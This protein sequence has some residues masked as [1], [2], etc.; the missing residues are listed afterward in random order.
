VLASPAIAP[1][2]SWAVTKLAASAWTALM[3]KPPLL[4]ILVAKARVTEDAL[5]MQAVVLVGTVVLTE[6]LAHPAASDPAAAAAALPVERPAA[7]SGNCRKTFA[8]VA[9]RGLGGSK[10][11]ALVALRVMEWVV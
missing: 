1:A 9:P 5:D 11:S 8:M 6:P 4:A 10:M 7:P 3:L 2:M